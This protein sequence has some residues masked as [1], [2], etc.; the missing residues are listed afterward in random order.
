M[1]DYIAARDILEAI[2]MASPMVLPAQVEAARLYQDWGGTG[3][4][5]QENYMRAIVGARAR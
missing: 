2:L 3:K 5:Q 4:G 1:G